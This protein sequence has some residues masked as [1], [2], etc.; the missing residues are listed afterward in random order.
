VNGRFQGRPPA[1]PPLRAS[2]KALAKWKHPRDDVIANVRATFL[3]DVRAR[4]LNIY[5]TAVSLMRNASPF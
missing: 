1:I 4:A 5:T 2:A 3:T